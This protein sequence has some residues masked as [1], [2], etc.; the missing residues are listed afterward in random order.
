MAII[1]PLL[2]FIISGVAGGIAADLMQLPATPPAEFTR[3][4][5][6]FGPIWIYL[7]WHNDL[8]SLGLQSPPKN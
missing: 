2:I 3:L 7:L 5:L 1:P 6:K 8:S 4:A